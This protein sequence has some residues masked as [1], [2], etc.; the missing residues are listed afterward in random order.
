MSIP[1]CGCVHPYV[2]VS[3]YTHPPQLSTVFH[4]CYM[5]SS[6]AGNKG[7]LVEQERGKDTDLAQEVVP[8]EGRHVAL[9]QRQQ[10]ELECVLVCCVPVC[11]VPVYLCACGLCNRVSSNRTTS[12]IGPPQ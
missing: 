6:H 3:I 11:C 9:L 7:R 12:V 5:L 2:H 4:Q 8:V 10:R 1:G